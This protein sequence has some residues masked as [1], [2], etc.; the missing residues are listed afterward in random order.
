MSKH[1]TR[2]PSNRYSDDGIK[3]N[4]Y[5]DDITWGGYFELHGDM[6]HILRFIELKCQSGRQRSPATGVE[7]AKQDERSS[8]WGLG[9]TERALGER[10]LLPICQTPQRAKVIRC[11]RGL[12]SGE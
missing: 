7:D 12:E 2:T 4:D 3:P 6:A 11:V 1:E 5:N 9:N 8:Q 10:L